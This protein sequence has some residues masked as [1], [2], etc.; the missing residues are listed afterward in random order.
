MKA[1][2]ESRPLSDEALAAIP[3][4][5]TMATAGHLDLAGLLGTIREM[6]KKIDT[7]ASTEFEMGLDEI[8]Q[9]LGMDLQADILQTLGDEWAMYLDPNTGGN[10]VLGI[11]LVNHLRDAGKA[12]KA[13]TQLEQ[14][15]NGMMKEGMAGEPVSIS[16]TTSTQG[17]L[18]I[19][20]LAV[21][22]VAPAWAIKD[23]NL[24]VGLYPQVVSG[25]AEHVRA[26]DPR[27]WRTKDSPR[28]AS[29]LAVKRSRRSASTISPR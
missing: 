22:F 14:L 17:D 29:G 28:C 4:S 20:Y 12:D 7:D 2:L 18:T 11:T 24:Y 6:V 25:A 16:F 8:K 1:L 23:G 21:P 27:S 5:A 15:L 3:K 13:L 26:R 10:G 19:H 9:A